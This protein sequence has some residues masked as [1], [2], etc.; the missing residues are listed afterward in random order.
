[1]RKKEDA[2]KRGLREL[3][4]TGISRLAKLHY[5][6]KALYTIDVTAA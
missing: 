4:L 1:M 3:K 5:S 2:Q 6:S